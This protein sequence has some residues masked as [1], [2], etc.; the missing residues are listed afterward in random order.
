MGWWMAVLYH[1]CM[2]TISDH[3]VTMLNEQLKVVEVRDVQWCHEPSTVYC[4]DRFLAGMLSQ[5]KRQ[6]L[7]VAA[8]LQVLFHLETPKAIPDVMGDD[9]IKAAIDLTDLCIQHAA[10]LAGG[11]NLE[12]IIHKISEG[13]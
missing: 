1:L 11:R 13:S 12:D 9:A 8:T 6:I 5:S 7:L 4:G 3:R 10:F 2:S